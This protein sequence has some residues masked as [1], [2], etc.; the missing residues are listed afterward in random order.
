MAEI[1]GGEKLQMYLTALSQRV[2]SAAAVKA[3]FLA[4]A[5]YPDGT[6]VAMV[7]AIQNFGAPAAGIPP[8]PFMTNAVRDGSEHWGED[9]GKALQASDFDANAALGM[10]G[11]QIAGE[12]RQSIQDT[13]SPA[14][15]P[16]TIKRKGFSK[17][18][19][20]SSVMWQSADY[21]VT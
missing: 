1:K 9:L 20:D 21:E 2:K 17:P 15:K 3:G 13:N 6:P 12:I 11:S 16:A 7:A 14:L 4:K 5:T 10:M 8:R 18:L 19:I